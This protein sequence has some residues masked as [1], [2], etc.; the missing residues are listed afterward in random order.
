[1]LQAPCSH[2]SMDS[3]GGAAGPISMTVHT[4]CRRRFDL[5]L[6]TPSV[7]L[8]QLREAIHA[9]LHV[10]IDAVRISVDGRQ[11]DEDALVQASDHVLLQHN[12]YGGAGGAA[13]GMEFKLVTTFPDAL[14]FRCLCAKC[15]IQD[16]PGTSDDWCTNK[17]LCI[18]QEVGLK[19]WMEQQCL[20]LL[21]STKGV[22]V[23]QTFPKLLAFRCLL[24]KC[25]VEDFPDVKKDDCCATSCCCIQKSLGLREWQVLQY[26]CLRLTITGDVANV[27]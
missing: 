2:P 12:V 3:D 23:E 18:H 9:Q 25:G 15:G 14:Q 20:C 8:Q 21:C 17:C 7:S 4:L 27:V 19:D 1:M 6:P 26:L 10:P 13:A 11:L 5:P 16:L 22:S 24:W